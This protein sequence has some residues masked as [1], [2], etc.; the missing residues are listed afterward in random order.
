MRA[1]NT[2]DPFLVATLSK[3]EQQLLKRLTVVEVIGK[4]NRPVPILL[5]EDMTK[6]VNALQ[7]SRGKCGV[8]SRNQFLF[9]LP[10]T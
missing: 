8:G 3:V 5:T 9:A 2:V 4:R 6:A 1:S 10:K 7:D